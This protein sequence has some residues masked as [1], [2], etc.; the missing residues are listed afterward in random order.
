MRE[1]RWGEGGGRGCG[2]RQPA[3]GHAS[4]PKEG[5]QQGRRT[6]HGL[7][8]DALAHALQVALG[9]QAQPARKESVDEGAGGAHDAQA[10]QRG[11]LSEDDDEGELLL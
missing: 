8:V 7:R 1:Q 11:G 4:C 5:S 6:R 2:E 3:V 10:R 9:R